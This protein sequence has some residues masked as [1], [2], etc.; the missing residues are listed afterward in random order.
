MR[1]PRRRGVLSPC[2]LTMTTHILTHFEVHLEAPRSTS[3]HLDIA[4][5]CFE[6]Q[7][8]QVHWASLPQLIGS[9]EAGEAATSAHND[10]AA[11]VQGLYPSPSP[12]PPH[13]RQRPTQAICGGACGAVL[14]T[15]HRESPP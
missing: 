8:K 13:H 10:R 4:S 5:R 3:K 15:K 2:G 11:R 1:R 9:G 12:Y 14:V 6:E 7:K